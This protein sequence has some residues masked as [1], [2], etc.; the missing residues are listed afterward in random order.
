MA[1]PKTSARSRK[2][3][4]E[5]KYVSETTLSPEEEHV[6]DQIRM[7]LFRDSPKGGLEHLK[8][9]EHI[10]GTH[11]NTEKCQ[12]PRVKNGSETPKLDGHSS[13]LPPV[14]KQRSK[15]GKLDLSGILR[16][17]NGFIENYF[18]ELSSKVKK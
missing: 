14:V 12:L 13:R 1:V 2:L 10:V 17:P 3:K 18:A 6:Q 15:S 11:N 16:D 4:S 8:K 9:H 5:F 7:L